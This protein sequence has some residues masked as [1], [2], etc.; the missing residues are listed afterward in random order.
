MRGRIEAFG[1]GS[2]R[3]QGA[4]GDLVERLR[5]WRL[6]AI[7]FCRHWLAVKTSTF[8]TFYEL[9]GEGKCNARAHRSIW[10][11]NYM[12]TPSKPALLS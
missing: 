4:N 6:K 3:E 9:Y 5:T 8:C 10:F 1:S 2:T 7:R 12:G 11:R